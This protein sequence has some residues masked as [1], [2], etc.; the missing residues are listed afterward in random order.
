LHPWADERSVQKRNDVLTFTGEPL[1]VPLDLAG[2]VHAR[3]AVGS[4]CSSMHLHVKLCDVFPDGSTRMLL[5]G[6]SFVREKEYGRPV[7][8]SLSHTAYRML[9]GHRLRLS[10]A[11]SDHPLYLWHPGTDQNPWLATKGQVNRQTLS[12]GGSSPSC[13]RLTIVL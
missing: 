3:L 11:S 13:I 2:P 5:R 12:A 8:F 6:E 4:T 10:I 1:V 9:P 7:R